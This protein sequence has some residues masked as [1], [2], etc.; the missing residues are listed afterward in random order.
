[1]PTNIVGAISCKTLQICVYFLF[2]PSPKEISHAK[3]VK[4]T[5]TFSNYNEHKARRDFKLTQE[6]K[7]NLPNSHAYVTQA[8]YSRRL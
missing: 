2:N 8:N 1:M 4:Q 5:I 7:T 3:K 6:L